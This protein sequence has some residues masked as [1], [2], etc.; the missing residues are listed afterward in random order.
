M[1]RLT[2]NVA[3][4]RPGTKRAPTATSLPPFKARTPAGRFLEFCATHLV[5]V[6]GPATGTP[7]ILAPWQV[8]EIV[9]PLFNTLLPDKRRQYRTCYLTCP[10][11]QG[12]STLGAALALY[13]TYAD[14]EG[15]AE[16]ISAAGSADQAAIIFDTAAAMVARSPA[17]SAM[18]MSYRRE[19]RVPSLGASYR[20]I[21]AEAGTAHGL[22]LHGAIIDELHVWPNRD[23]YDALTTAT[24]ARAQPLVFIATTAGDEEHS[25]CAEVHRRAEAVRDGLAPDPTLLPV[26]YAAP[27]DADW[28]DEA[29]WR[30]C[31][32]ALGKFRSLEEMRSAAQQATEVPG[33]EAPFRRFYLNQWG[34]NQAERWLDLAAWDA[35]A[36]TARPARGRR[37][38]LGL[39][40]SNTTDLSALV[41]LLPEDD[42]SYDVL[43]D[44]WCPEEGIKRRSEQDRVPYA[45]WVQEGYLTATPGN[46]IEYPFIEAR[47]W[48]LMAE[49]DVQEIGVDP[50]NAR[51]WIAQ[52]FRDNLPVVVVEQNMAN[53]SSASKA[54]EGLI[55]KRQL[56]HGGHP[57]L[58]WCVSNAVAVY[59]ANENVRPTKD[60]KKS[61]GRI[62]GVSALVT[63]LA[64]AILATSGSV[65]DQRGLTVV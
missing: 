38:F 36:T 39:D 64:R 25:I 1:P 37:A 46:V 52:W 58:R 49:Y 35:C 20:V 53:L 11:K 2:R 42:G 21:S 4:I 17:L 32:P 47:M 55:L 26:I 62:D 51:G 50:W 63:G 27:K 9:R 8:N 14:G 28:Q 31:N 30:A 59:D 7:L 48:A 6:K 15:G 41:C 60:K 40:L 5:H 56:R 65:Y 45:Q 24:G 22:N 13:L 23:L 19:L 29:V 43:V 33:R 12:K 44:F 18:T 57:V 16:I 3:Y 54:L 34:V 10:R 61:H